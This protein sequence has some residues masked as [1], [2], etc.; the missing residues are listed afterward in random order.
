MANGIGFFEKYLSVWVFFCI[1]FGI[2]LG[3]FIP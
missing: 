3:N 1:V 2:L